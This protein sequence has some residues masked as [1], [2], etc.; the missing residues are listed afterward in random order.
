VRRLRPLTG[1]LAVFASAFDPVTR[2]LDQGAADVLG[3]LEGWARSTQARDAASHVFRFGVT[4]GPGTFT[5][6]AP[7]LN[8]AATK[9][10][11]H[12]RQPVG[13]RKIGAVAS[14]AIS[15]PSLSPPPP[16]ALPKPLAGLSLSSRVKQAQATVQHLLQQVGL[17][18]G[19]APGPA[20]A[21]NS[22]NSL[23]N[24][25]NYLLK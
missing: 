15:V 8:A 5:S 20:P 4:V 7:L 16:K 13:Q 22:A 6:L 2:T 14:P 21:A 1:E 24:L 10:A 11:T 18:G 23:Q 25:I 3:V 9:T 17:G 19:T 12:R